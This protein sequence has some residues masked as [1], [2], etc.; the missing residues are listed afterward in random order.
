MLRLRALSSA[1]ATIFRSEI[2]SSIK[3]C[4]EPLCCLRL[5]DFVPGRFFATAIR[6]ILFARP[7]A[8]LI[9]HNDAYD[10]AAFRV[11]CTW[12]SRD[13]I[14]SEEPPIQQRE[15]IEW[16]PNYNR[17]VRLSLTSTLR[18]IALVAPDVEGSE[19]ARSASISTRE[20]SRRRRCFG[21]QQHERA[22]GVLMRVKRMRVANA[23]STKDVSFN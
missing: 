14:V 9:Q 18:L 21:S 10:H 4:S 22:V 3:A 17:N 2:T 8:G 20:W 16:S 1:F 5:P 7:D 13:W 6:I 23:T 19:G 11:A 15:L 12:Q